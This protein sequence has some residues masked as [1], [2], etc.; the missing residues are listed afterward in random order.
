MGIIESVWMIAET[1]HEDEASTMDALPDL[2]YFSSKDEAEEE[3]RKMNVSAEHGYFEYLESHKEREKI[4][5]ENLDTY[6]RAKE[7]LEKNGI[8]DD[9]IRVPTM[10][11][12]YTLEEWKRYFYSGYHYSAIEILPH[13]KQKL[14]DNM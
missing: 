9:L 3:T 13:S 8:D 2:G 11:S 10:N 14:H 5:K 7:L 1:Y 6:H 4:Y 12:P